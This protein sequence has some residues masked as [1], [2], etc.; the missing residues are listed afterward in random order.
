VAI[1][2]EKMFKGNAGYLERNISPLCTTG[3][4]QVDDRVF[5]WDDGFI[6]KKK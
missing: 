2:L 6:V 5:Q 3:N 4:E 1:N